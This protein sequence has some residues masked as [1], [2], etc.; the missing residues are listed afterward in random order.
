LAQILPP[1]SLAPPPGLSSSPLAGKLPKAGGAVKA[2]ARLLPPPPGELRPC[3]EKPPAS[4]V[5]KQDI[6]AVR[7]ME[8]ALG[9]LR[10]SMHPDAFSRVCDVLKFGKRGDLAVEDRAT[11]RWLRRQLEDEMS[12]SLDRM[13]NSAYS[14]LSTDA[15]SP[16]STPTASEATL[17]SLTPS[18]Q[19]FEADVG[20]GIFV[21]Q[22][23]PESFRIAR[24]PPG[25]ASPQVQGQLKL[26]Q[27]RL[28]KVQQA[29]LEE[30]LLLQM[31]QQ[32]QQM[33]QHVG[34]M[35]SL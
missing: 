15:Y 24:Q 23:K 9:S 30:M 31:Q 10:T 18:I 28:S 4:P 29:Q 32:K 25:Q 17:P 3:V 27:Q 5:G 26:A 22:D 2:K 14:P 21:E 20:L 33:P 12:D 7:L 16:W 8:M 13:S 11:I 34:Y 35:F 19:D 6:D 1:P